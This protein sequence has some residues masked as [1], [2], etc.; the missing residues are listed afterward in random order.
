VTSYLSDDDYYA[1]GV[2][3]CNHFLKLFLVSA[4]SGEIVG[5][6]A[7]DSSLG[8]NVVIISDTARH[9]HLQNASATL[10]LMVGSEIISKFTG[11]VGFAGKGRM[12]NTLAT[13]C[14]E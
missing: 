9:F 13:V 4:S 6:F 10:T 8:S 12:I 14:E 2:K 7:P 1:C 11:V 5:G 3:L